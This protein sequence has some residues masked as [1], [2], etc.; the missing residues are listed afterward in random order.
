MEIKNLKLAELRLNPT[1]PREV[2][3]EK[4]KQLIDSI[5]V[6]PK[7]MELRPVVYNARREVLGGNMRLRALQDI[8]QMSLEDIKARLECLEGYRSKPQAERVALLELW[9]RW[10]DSPYA[11]A[12][13]AEGL[14]DAEQQEFIIKDNL[15][16]GKWDWD[17]LADDWDETQL[18][19]WGLDVW[20]P[21]QEEETPETKEDE[22]NEDNVET[23]CKRGDIWQLGKHRLMCGDATSSDDVEKL[24]GGETM[25]LL[26]TDPP[27]GIDI[28]CHPETVGDFKNPK[29]FGKTVGEGLGIVKATIYHKIK[30]DETTE[31]ARLSYEL[32]KNRSKNQIIFGGNYFTDFLP[33]K[34]CWVVWDK[35]NGNSVFADIELAWT[36][37]DGGARLFQWLW[38]GMARAGDRKTEGLKRIHPTQK[39][40]GL[41]VKI[42]NEF[43]QKGTK[44]IDLFAGSGTLAIAAE[45]FGCQAYLMEYEDFYCD[46]I[47]DRWE[48]YTG[49]KA[50]KIN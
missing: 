23:R 41:F 28:V 13:S 4:Y 11:P 30:G 15:S 42:L 27:Y 2:V 14:T 3:E 44:V 34:A 8:A 32:M 26:L 40:V 48:Q 6:F 39:P 20:Q 16:F 19:E 29:M 7:M 38:N 36:S 33:P 22:Y 25:D 24:T 31:T 18:E 1:N 21:E 45:Q 37:F 50:I 12:A 17:A 5:L 43:S 35:M 9:Q 49:E 10:L 46:I 47:I